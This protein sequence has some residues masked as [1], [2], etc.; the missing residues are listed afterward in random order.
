MHDSFDSYSLLS[1]QGG[2]VSNDK[3]K[4]MINQ[5][6]TFDVYN[7]LDSKIRGQRSK[8]S[9]MGSDPLSES[10]GK[11]NANATVQGLPKY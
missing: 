1:A 7:Q 9:L 2:K 5:K 10:P 11:L 8:K 3:L 6:N 4:F